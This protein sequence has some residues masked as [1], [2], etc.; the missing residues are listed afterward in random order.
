MALE[1]LEAARRLDVKW[2]SAGL[3]FPLRLRIGV[4]T[5]YCTV[6]DFGSQQR[7]DYTVVGHQVNLAARIEKSAAPNSILLSH[8]TWSLVR[9][10]ITAEEQAPIQVKGVHAP[11]QT[12]KVTGRVGERPSDVIE[13]AGE[14]VS[15]KIDLATADRAEA[16]RILEAAL[17]TLG[18]EKTRTSERQTYTH[19]SKENGSQPSDSISMAK[20]TPRETSWFLSLTPATCVVREK[21][22]SASGAPSVTASSRRATPRR[23]PPAGASTGVSSTN[24]KGSPAS[25]V[26]PIETLARKSPLCGAKAKALSSGAGR[27]ALRGVAGTQ[28]GAG[29]RALG[30]DDEVAIDAGREARTDPDREFREVAQSGRRRLRVFLDGDDDVPGPEADDVLESLAQQRNEASRLQPQ[31]KFSADV[32]AP[33]LDALELGEGVGTRRPKTPCA[34]AGRAAPSCERA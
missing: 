8:E 14:G 12:Y 26:M 18:E 30:L 25:T 28:D 22:I 17:K 29:V 1:M 2:R 32:G 11:V 5:G 33:R 6:G 15:V 10:Q 31:Q 9:D 24:P 23:R 19:F 16:K 27:R 4:N 13:E 7:M 21:A 34:D 20:A 3:A